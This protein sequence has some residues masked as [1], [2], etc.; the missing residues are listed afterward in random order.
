MILRD[1]KIFNCYLNVYVYWFKKNLFLLTTS[2]WLKICCFVLI[3]L[4]CIKI[5]FKWFSK[6]VLICIAYMQGG[7]TSPLCID[8]YSVYVYK[9]ELD[10]F[11]Y[12]VHVC[13]ESLTS[14]SIHYILC[15]YGLGFSYLCF[16]WCMYAGGV[17]LTFLLFMNLYGIY[18]YLVCFSSSLCWWIDK[19]GRRIE[20]VYICML[21]FFLYIYI[22][23]C[24]IFSLCAFIEYLYVFAMHELRWSFYEA[25]L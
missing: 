2:G 5:Y 15:L 7:L 11:F 4:N 9:E 23:F 18:F 3:V 21:C 25:Y 19:K 16:I 24:L 13:R 12:M 8:S 20:R 1:I 17:N 22:C 14:P 10:L 6:F